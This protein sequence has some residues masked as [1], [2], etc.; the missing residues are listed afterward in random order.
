M[1]RE[2]SPSRRSRTPRTDRFEAAAFHGNCPRCAYPWPLPFV[3]SLD[4]PPPTPAPNRCPECGLTHAARHR[5]THAYRENTALQRHHRR[6]LGI[7]AP[8]LYIL[9]LAAIF[10]PM[11]V[12]VLFATTG[13]GGLIAR[14]PLYIVTLGVWVIGPLF[15]AILC[16]RLFKGD[17][18]DRLLCGR[19]HRWAA[20]CA[21]APIAL[22]S[23]LLLLLFSGYDPTGWAAN[24]VLI[25]LFVLGLGGLLALPIFTARR[26]T[27]IAARRGAFPYARRAERLVRTIV[28]V[29]ALAA[30]PFILQAVLITFPGMPGTGAVVGL[31]STLL[32]LVTLVAVVV[33]LS[34]TISAMYQVRRV[35]HEGPMPFT[36]PPSPASPGPASASAPAP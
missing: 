6:T 31:P 24:A 2:R 21:V 32:S 5:F 36:P 16:M 20:W 4:G 28:I 22:F 26:L 17:R 25:P 18:A 15:G 30:T 29:Y 27:V 9:P 10:G 12:M 33:V 3:A 35:L 1:T 14:L 19:E 7:L 34:K 8:L 11:I 13:G 23:T